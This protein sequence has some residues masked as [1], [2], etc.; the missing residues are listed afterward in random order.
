ME[1]KTNQ[2]VPFHSILK[3]VLNNGTVQVVFEKVD[4]SIRV[5][6]CTTNSAKIISITGELDNSDEV[7]TAK[8]TRKESTSVI[9]VFEVDEAK[10][11]SFKLDKLISINS[12]KVEEILKLIPKV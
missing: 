8:T 10:W 3:A 7:Y 6:N 11:K 1:L 4:G 9:S 12:V 5:L 2:L